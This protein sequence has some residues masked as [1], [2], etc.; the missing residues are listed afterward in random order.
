MEVALGNLSQSLGGRGCVFVHQTTHPGRLLR[1][2][3]IRLKGDLPV[4]GF[5]GAALTGSRFC[6][7]RSSVVQISAFE[8]SCDLA[9]PWP[10]AG[11]SLPDLL[12]LESKA[13]ED[14]AWRVSDACLH[15]KTSGLIYSKQMRGI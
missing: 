2:G 13:T 14:S 15:A 6:S 12:Q 8:E 3:N 10:Q 11:G 9:R 5:V 4:G 1:L 7:G